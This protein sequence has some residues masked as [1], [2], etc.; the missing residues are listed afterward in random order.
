MKLI[1]TKISGP[2]LIKSKIF[3]DKR[4]YLRETYKG[5]LIKKEKFPFDVMSFSKRNVLRGLHLQI[6]KTQAKIITVTYGKIFDVAVDLRKNSKTFGK[7]IGII[8][9]DKSDFSFYIPKGFAHGFLCLSKKCT[10]NYKCS[11]YRDPNSEKTLLWSDQ[12]LNIKWPVKRPILSKKDRNG[13]SL[14]DFR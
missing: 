11:N 5:S 10:V 1:K 3:K 4:G 8:I 13:L 7:Y 6:K 9:S 14:T 2:K 12:S